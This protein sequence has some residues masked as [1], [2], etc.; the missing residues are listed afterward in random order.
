MH[1]AAPFSLVSHSAS[2]TLTTNQPS[3]AGPS[4]YSV[5]SSRASSIRGG[6]RR[7][8]ARS[9]RSAPLLGE[10]ELILMS[11]RRPFVDR[12]VFDDVDTIAAELKKAPLLQPTEKR[13]ALLQRLE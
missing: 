1:A 5:R 13:E 10:C 3:L 4:P 8:G 12:N 9:R 6:A 2:R 7:R 11:R